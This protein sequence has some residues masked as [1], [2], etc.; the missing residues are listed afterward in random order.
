MHNGPLCPDNAGA[1]F[2][3]R[4]DYY[5]PDPEPSDPYEIF[6]PAQGKV[7]FQESVTAG[8]KLRSLNV[9]DRWSI[10]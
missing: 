5:E 8:R 9:T 1:E 6:I 2:F 7:I 10:A 4:T 3:S